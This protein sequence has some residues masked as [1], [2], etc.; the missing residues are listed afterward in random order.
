MKCIDSSCPIF[1]AKSALRKKH[2]LEKRVDKK[3]NALHNIQILLEQIH[4]THNDAHVWEAYKNA[5]TAFDA[6]FKDNGLSESAIEDTMI[7]L[8]DVRDCLCLCYSIR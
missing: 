5:L 7:K 2:E 8:S 4:E 6:T 3:M 1:Q